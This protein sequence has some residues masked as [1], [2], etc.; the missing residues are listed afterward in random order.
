MIGCDC[1]V[2]ASPDP[3]DKRMRPSLLVTVRTPGEEERHILVDTTPEMR[4]QALRAGVGRVDAVL[5]THTHADHIFGMDDIRQFNW[6]HQ[7]PMSVYGTEE[8]LGHLRRTFDYCFKETQTGGGKPQLV[9]ESFEPYRPFELFGVTVT[10]LTVL[11]GRMP[12]TAFKF[13]DRFAY[14]TDVSTIPG[15][16]RPH[17]A[18][19]DTLILGAV[20][21]EPHPTHF[22]LSEAV[23][24]AQGFRPRQTYL[25][26]LS[27]HFRH[28]SVDAD[29]P[30]GV[31]LGYD[32]LAFAVPGAGGN[33]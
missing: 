15:E 20:R 11:H 21:Y 33:P 8:T 3:R 22:S 18:G 1:A 5:V 4:L 30:T 32:G 6:K 12:V 24:E 14:V 19:L 10:P 9:L 13:G 27:H 31:N 17:L 23:E 16:T 26:H 2:C 28:A 7:R 25:T 29:L